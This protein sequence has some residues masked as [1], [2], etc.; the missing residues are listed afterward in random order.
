M[1]FRLSP[2]TLKKWRRRRTDRVG[3]YRVFDVFR[4][5]MEDGAGAPRPTVFTFECPDWTNVVAVTDARELVM[6]WQ[7]RF[8]TDELSL[9]VPGG[10]VDPGEEPLEAARRELLEETGYAAE[11]IAP[12]LV[13]E[14]NPALQN[15]RCTT[16]LAQGVRRVAEP[17]FDAAEELEVVLVPEHAVADVLDSGHVTHALVHSALEVYL[18]R[19][20]VT[21]RR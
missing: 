3:G 21:S 10:V 16:V 19:G 4:H 6:V 20:R 7:Y 15:N 5:D 9:E 14:P 8:G 11:S 18:R 13:V 1:G 2:P 17:Q 12:L